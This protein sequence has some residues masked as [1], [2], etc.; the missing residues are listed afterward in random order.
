MNKPQYYVTDV[1]SKEAFRQ[2]VIIALCSNP[3]LIWGSHPNNLEQ[4]IP[5]IITLADAIVEEAE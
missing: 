3:Q 5:N 2:A 1:L 4:Q